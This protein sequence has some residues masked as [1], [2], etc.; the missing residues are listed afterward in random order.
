MSR[1]NL[2]STSYL[3]L[4]C[5][6]VRGPQTPYALK[7]FV[8]RSIGN[9]WSFPHSQLYAEPARLADAGLLREDREDAGRR[10]RVFRITPTGL[11]ALREWLAEPT[12]ELPEIRH[13]GLL[14]LFF[15]AA[16][17]PDQVRELAARQ[18][19]A[20]AGKLAHMEAVLASHGDRPELVH[21]MATLRL[22]IQMMR[23][24]MDFWREVAANPPMSGPRRRRR[25]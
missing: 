19:A 20:H 10:R 6:A 5:I 14:K 23:A 15:G 11:A 7:D 4:G 17:D 25:A 2:S 8:G 18:A 12:D 9:F 1:P 24:G 21:Q 22:G 13:L 3:V 16:G